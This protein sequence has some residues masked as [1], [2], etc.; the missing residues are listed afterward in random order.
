MCLF[1]SPMLVLY[2]AGVAVAYFVHPSRR[3]AKELAGS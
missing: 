3:K 1:A 2:L